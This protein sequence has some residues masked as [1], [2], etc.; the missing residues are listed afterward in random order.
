MKTL[1]LSISI[2][3]ISLTAC[4]SN[5]NT[6]AK[7]QNSMD[8]LASQKTAEETGTKSSIEVRRYSSS[9]KEIVINYLQL[10]N[11]LAEDN[12]AEAA[13]SGTKLEAAFKNFDKTELSATQK[14]TFEDVEGD[15]R[16]HAEH[17]GANSGNIAHQRE[18]FEILSKDIYD[19]IKSFG[20]GQTLY[21]IHCPTYNNGKGAY[22]ISETKEIKNPYLGKA[23]PGCGEIK[24]ELK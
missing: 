8:S 1:F 2:A 4:N 5:S 7:V 23:M 20:A 22:W 16:E 3:V 21:N 24:E 9:I 19:F 18:H 15:A 17:I 12:T 10:K 11:A 13:T 6:S 14:K